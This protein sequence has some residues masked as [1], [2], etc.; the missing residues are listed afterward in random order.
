MIVHG[1]NVTI[2]NVSSYLAAIENFPSDEKNGYIFRGQANI[3]WELKPKAGRKEFFP[4]VEKD[5]PNCKDQDLRI[6][7]EW[8]EQAIAFSPHIPSHDLEALAYAQHYGLATRLLDWSTNA[9]VA[10]Y[11]AVES[12]SPTDGAVFSYEQE[13]MADLDT[14]ITDL[15][16]FCSIHVRP[17]DKRLAAQSGCFTFHPKPQLPF[18]EDYDMGGG[19]VRTYAPKLYKLPILASYKSP[20]KAELARIGINAKSIYPDLIGLGTHLNWK[21]QQRKALIEDSADSTTIPRISHSSSVPPGQPN[22][23]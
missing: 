11:F 23:A 6:F 20:L 22:S 19:L 15:L 2:T 3:N 14:P 21:L 10:L 5:H 12:E 4:T 18:Q 1:T 16:I 13:I 17:F 8:R 9:L 7:Q